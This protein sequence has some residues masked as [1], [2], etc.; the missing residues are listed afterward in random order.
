MSRLRAGCLVSL[1]AVALAGCGG[2]S[3]SD[4]SRVVPDGPETR[5]PAGCWRHLAQDA[6]DGRIDAGYPPSCYAAAIAHLPVDAYTPLRAVLEEGMTQASGALVPPER[7]WSSV[8]RSVVHGRAGAR[9]AL[10][11]WESSLAADRLSATPTH[12]RTPSR[13]WMLRRLRRL[14][15][16]YHFRVIGFRYLHRFDNGPRPAPLLI[17]RAAPESF[18]RATKLVI[19]TLDQQPRAGSHQRVA[20]NYEAFFLEAR[21]QF[22]APFLAVFNN[23]RLP[24]Q[25]GGQWASSGNLY[26]FAHG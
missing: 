5:A 13:A 23:W 20:W 10:V 26:P 17:V 11:A 3:S 9:R 6:Y 1:A 22:G 21:D 4:R 12:F 19:A 8:R 25:E 2:A 24:D 18:V 16:I 14:Q 15:S 7:L